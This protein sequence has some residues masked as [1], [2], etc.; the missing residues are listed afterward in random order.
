MRLT[1]TVSLTGLAVCILLTSV[2]L[3]GNVLAQSGTS[4]VRGTVADPTGKTINGATV[5]IS[6]EEKNFSRTQSTGSDGGYVF[7]SIPPGV[8]RVDAEASG[9]KKTS[10]SDVKA[11]VDT[12]VDVSVQLEVG[13]VSDVVQ[14]SAASEAPINTTDA[15][16]GNAFENR[17]IIELPLNARN[18]VNLLSLQPG[19]TAT[20]E[21]NGGRRDQSNITLD[22]ADVNE[23]QSGLDIVSPADQQAFS[24]VLRTTPDSVQEFRVTTAN[25]NANQGRSSGAQVS[26]VTRSGSNQF[27]GSAYWYHRN[28]VTTANDFF[29]NAQ[30]R[31]T[32]T[33][34]AVIAGRA[35]AGDERS[36]RPKLIR[37]LF[38]GSIGGP[39]IPDR[40]FFFYNYE[41]RRDASQTRVVRTVPTATLRTGVV[42]F[43]NQSGGTTTLTPADIARLYPTTGGVNQAGLAVLQ[44]ALLPN[45]SEQ[46]DGLN[47]GAFA[48]NASTPSILAVHIARLDFNLTSNHTL[49]VR[50]N[51]QDDNYNQAPQFPNTPAPSLWVNP[52]GF[53]V[54]HTWTISNALINNAR[55][56]LTRQ[57]FSSQGDSSSNFFNFRFVYQPFLYSRTVSRT[58][59]VHN[60]TDDLSWIKGTHTA[61]FG[62]NIRLI[63]NHRVSYQNS[64]DS[65]IVNQSF[66]A[67]SGAVLS[68]PLSALPT[69]QQP[70]SGSLFDVRSAVSAVI[71][72][73]SQYS[74]NFVFSKD[75]KI[76]SSGTPTDRTFA[77]EEYEFYAQD[78][79][80]VRPNLTLTYGLRYSLSTPVYETQGFQAR[81]TTSLGEFFDLRRRSADNGIPV[82]DLITVDLGGKANDAP[83]YYSMDKNNF[84]PSFA[85]AYSP[86]FGDNLFGKAFGRSGKSVIRAGFRMLYDRVGSALAVNFDL[87]NTLGFT[88][89]SQISANTF[90]VSTRLA[91]AFT[92]LNQDVRGLPQL[93]I[94]GNLVFP[95]SKP[96]NE[97]A[98]I[99]R[100]IDDTLKTPLQY[101]WNLTYARELGKG[102]S[103][104]ASY[105]GRAGRDLIAA[106]DVMHL[107]NLRDRVSG[108]TW[109]EAAGL[110]ANLRERGLSFNES[111]RSFNLPIPNIPFFENL[112]PGARIRTG[113]ENYDGSAFPF[114]SGLS[115]SQQ[116]AWIV[117][118]GGYNFTDYTS[119]QDMLDDVSVIGRNAYFH[120]QYAAFAVYSTVGL[121]D[122]NGLSFSLRQRF[123]N[124]IAFDVNY[125][126][127]HSFDT[128]ST[129]ESTTDPFSAGLIRNPLNVRGARASSDFDVRHLINANWLVGLPFGKDKKFMSNAN[130][131]VDA[132][133]GGWQLTGVV[134]YNSGLPASASDIGLWATNWNFTSRGVRLREVETGSF[135]N[136]N[137]RPNLFADPTAAYRSFRNARAGEDGDRNVLRLPSYFVMDAGLSKYFR[138][139]G[140]EKHRLQFRWEVFNVT[141]TQRMGGTVNGVSGVETLGLNQDPFSASSARTG[142]GR[143]ISEQRPVGE[144]RPGRVMQFALRYEF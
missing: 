2:V 93:T 139:P 85:I 36:P 113:A 87:N 69:A 128:G 115:P 72:R 68:D 129:L 71:G 67:G 104:E 64:Y 37:N 43:P 5:T 8:Y 33:D 79:W 103:F 32:A 88:S 9:F 106:R 90:N 132:I 100:T 57:A 142:F 73:L 141:N 107:N 62:T 22:G 58:T 125:T 114:L 112:Y 34:P 122:Y 23:Q 108:Q 12:S 66:F 76:Q 101:M 133:I 117:A 70:T 55:Y 41:G 75:G 1:K 18:I 63:R 96:A 82:N 47:V 52:K 131:F 137:G 84:A 65:F 35:T 4:A 44:Q 27:H 14:V 78:F 11:L 92:G 20:G 24:A 38:G 26:L 98:R 15:S 124:D 126:L 97:A 99:E 123:S 16:I 83:G 19:V 17:R 53:V 74:A 121:S 3:A 7:N 143:F 45:S 54:G 136:V 13:S 94:P 95:L 51:Y 111:T 127:S 25:P 28:T 50:G 135:P 120:P 21:V 119:V 6:N 130:S 89:A 81:P 138:I 116:A 118:R 140:T 10:V 49:F 61:Q 77:T 60:I 86:D 105:V 102:F 48:F 59:P 56:G 91:P 30:G 80:K 40:A 109:Y 42:R 31:F 134:R 29:G 46:G 144:S 39:I 110:L